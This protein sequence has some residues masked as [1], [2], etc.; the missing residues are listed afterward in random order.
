VEREERREARVAAQRAAL[1]DADLEA[2]EFAGVAALIDALALLVVPDRPNDPA[3]AAGASAPIGAAAGWHYEAPAGWAVSHVPLSMEWDKSLW[4]RPA[5]RHFGSGDGDGEESTSVG[6]LEMQKNER[7][8]PQIF[9]N[10][11]RM[12]IANRPV[13]FSG[14]LKHSKGL[15]L[16]ATVKM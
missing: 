2:P 4:E 1:A 13:S 8:R 3:T 11:L 9:L 16:R 15:Q 14:S 7:G 10:F 6:P 5:G 12:R